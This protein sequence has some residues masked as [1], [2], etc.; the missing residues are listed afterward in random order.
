MAEK[1]KKKKI[2]DTI[3]V[4]IKGKQDTEMTYQRLGLFSAFF[5]V[6]QSPVQ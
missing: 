5:N 1:R 6:W 4:N 3:K 2:E